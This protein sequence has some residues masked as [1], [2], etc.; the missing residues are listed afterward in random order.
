MKRHRFDHIRDFDSLLAEVRAAEQEVRESDKL[1]GK[2]TRRAQVVH[3]PLQ[4]RARTTL[5]NTPSESTEFSSMKSTV[6]EV[7]R[8]VNALEAEISQ[9]TSRTKTSLCTSIAEKM[10][11]GGKEPSATVI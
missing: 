11:W 5:A 7:M 4:E 2:S 1:W 10:E 6:E 3:L 8:K 9:Q